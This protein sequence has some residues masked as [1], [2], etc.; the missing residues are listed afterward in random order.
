MNEFLSTT[1]AADLLRKS[2]AAVRNLVMRRAI[3]YR[4]PG[5]RL[6]FIRDELLEW[7][8]QAPGVSIN[9][10]KMGRPSEGRAREGQRR[11]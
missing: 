10:L 4:K 6:V 1:E 2:P 3:P 9:D 8:R 11:S 7:V 5:G